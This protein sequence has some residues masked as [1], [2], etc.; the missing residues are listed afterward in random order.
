MK[1]QPK[2][3]SR[4]PKLKGKKDPKATNADSARQKARDRPERSK[5]SSS[6]SRQEERRRTLDAELR[7]VGDILWREDADEDEMDSGSLF[8]VG[9]LDTQ[10]GFL[11]GGGGGGVP[12]F[13]GVGYVTGVEQD[14]NEERLSRRRNRLRRS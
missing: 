10:K 7:R 11:S 13:M 8:G 9:T 14:E 5:R 1:T 2:P 4:I 3:T 12:V 6:A